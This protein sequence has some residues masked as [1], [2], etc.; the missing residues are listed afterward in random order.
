MDQIDLRLVL[1]ALAV[2]AGG[3]TKGITGI[4]L[5]VVATPILAI[6][7][8]LPTA[9]AVV[10]LPTVFT[11]AALMYRF[12]DQWREAR[13]LIPIIPPALVGIVIGT[14]ILIRV[15]QH[16]LK[17]VLGSAVLLFVAMSWFHLVP[18]LGES[19]ARRWGPG[20][21]L[22]AGMLQGASGTSAPV[23]TIF[24]FQ[25]NL[26]KAPF[27]F[28]INAFFFLVDT[29]QVLSLV[30]VGIYTPRLFLVSG[31]IACLALPVLFMTLRL[32]ERISDQLFRKA[33]LLV[34]TLTGLVLVANS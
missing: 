11:A 2:L 6:L 15:D 12:R 28:V 1:G 5:P 10:I 3:V 33:V 16:L 18:R 21:G 24:F 9:I 17:I 30:G 34:L 20:V 22:A 13:R 31:A 4:G 26:A 23:V 19:F 32:Q 25:V 7:Y 27:L 8:D 14:Q 29:G